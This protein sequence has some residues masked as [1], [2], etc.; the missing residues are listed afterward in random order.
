M[1]YSVEKQPTS[2]AELLQMAREVAALD[3]SHGAG[4]LETYIDENDADEPEEDES[5]FERSEK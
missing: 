3:A 5:C 2:L 1:T 4:S